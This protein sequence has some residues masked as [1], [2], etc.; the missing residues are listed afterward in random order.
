[1]IFNF[2]KLYFFHNFS[3]SIGTTSTLASLIFSKEKVDLTNQLIE[4]LKKKVGKVF[5]NQTIIEGIHAEGPVI[6]S[7]GI[8]FFISLLSATRIHK[9][10]SLFCD[11]CSRIDTK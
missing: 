5:P 10:D 8:N 1:M 3:Y 7:K 6:R 2:S 9:L 11:Y 4:A